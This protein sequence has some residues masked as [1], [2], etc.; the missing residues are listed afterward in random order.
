MESNQI[1]NG[2]ERGPL[3]ID[4]RLNKILLDA[5][6]E[7]LAAFG[8]PIAQAILF[9]VEKRGGV[10]R[11]EIPR[12]PADFEAALW[13]VFGEGTPVILRSITSCLL[14][15][16]G[17]PQDRQPR[18]TDFSKIVQAARAWLA[19]NYSSPKSSL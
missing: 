15:A 10:A 5:V 14:Q 16:T 11:E 3:D 17:L 8:Q 7:G 2:K 1:G 19:A 4:D 13:A 18:G 6:Y 12:R 9:Y